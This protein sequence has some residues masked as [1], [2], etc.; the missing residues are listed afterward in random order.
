[1]EKAARGVDGRYLPWGDFFE[2][3]YACVVDSRDGPPGPTS[4]RHFPIDESPYG[5]RGMAGNVRDWCL[6]RWERDGPEV[7]DGVL[8]WVSAPPDDP[9]F[10]SVRG[11]AWT[12]VAERVRMASRFAAKPD[13]RFRGQGFR[14]ARSLP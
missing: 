8:R 1:M 2:H 4:V 13:D 11:G 3:T 5:V 12:A 14:L 9:G 10:R 7:V 6:D